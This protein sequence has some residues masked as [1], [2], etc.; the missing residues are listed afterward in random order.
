MKKTKSGAL[1]QLVA[2]LIAS[3]CHLYWTWPTYALNLW[4]TE[5][6]AHVTYLTTTKLEFRFFNEFEGKE[7]SFTRDLVKDEKQQFDNHGIRVRYTKLLADEAV[8]LGLD[9]IPKL[10]LPVTVHLAF[11][12]TIIACFKEVMKAFN[13]GSVVEGQ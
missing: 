6:G 3:A 9:R 13:K 8:I 12:F 2:V 7:V 11:L 5:T 4:Y 1:T 10:W